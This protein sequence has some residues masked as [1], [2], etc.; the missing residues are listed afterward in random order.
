MAP[1]VAPRATFSPDRPAANV[2]SWKFALNGVSASGV[3]FR[4][5][6]AV[7]AR[8]GRLIKRGKLRPAAK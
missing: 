4:A 3:E 8:F 7:T 1:G 6:Q 5:H 2:L